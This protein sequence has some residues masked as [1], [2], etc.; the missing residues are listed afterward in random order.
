ML[1][2]LLAGAAYAIL[3][4]APISPAGPALSG[5][6]FLG[7][8]SWALI[9]PDSY[10]GVWP[11]GIA[12][13]GFDLSRPGYALA[14]MLAVPMLCTALSARR[15]ARYEPPEVP[16]FGT[17]GR[18]RGNAP[19]AGTSIATEQTAIFSTGDPTEFIAV[20][21]AGAV[22][23]PAESPTEAVPTQPV[24]TQATPAGNG[25]EPTAATAETITAEEE[26]TAESAPT[27]AGEEPTVIVAETATAEEEP[28]VP[29]AA[30]ETAEAEEPTAAN[31]S[32]DEHTLSSSADD[33]PTDGVADAGA[34]KQ[35]ESES[36]PGEPTVVMVGLPVAPDEPERGR[37]G[38]FGG[39]R[40][41]GSRGRGNHRCHGVRRAGRREHGGRPTARCLS[42]R[43]AHRDR[44]P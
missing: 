34:D 32:A 8:G 5:L 44:G 9:A 16:I 24:P 42:S 1:L 4:F 14:A 40:R 43:R 33:Q 29:T 35:D 15:W 36:S 18:V 30:A 20:P 3:I 31:A 22:S 2:L 6:V 19:V 38:R 12:K 21:T 27:A 10:A 28:T 25:D 26:P 41:R 37:H 13:E 39:N 7:V 17:I 11:A 23:A